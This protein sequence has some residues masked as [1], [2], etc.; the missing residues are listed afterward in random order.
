M[1][2][3]PKDTA[4]MMADRQMVGSRAFISELTGGTADKPNRGVNIKLS[5]VTAE[6]AAGHREANAKLLNTAF[7]KDEDLDPIQGFGF[8]GDEVEFE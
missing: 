2:F 1:G 7:D 8:D 4:A 5:Y 3:V 6:E